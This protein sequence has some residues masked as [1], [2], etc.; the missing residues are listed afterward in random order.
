MTK[1]EKVISMSLKARFPDRHLGF[2]LL[3]VS[4]KKCLMPSCFGI[5]YSFS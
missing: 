1:R 5:T 3:Q 2:R 4:F